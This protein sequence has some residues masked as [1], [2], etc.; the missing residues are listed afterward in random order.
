MTHAI[1]QKGNWF[2]AYKAFLFDKDESLVLK[3][4]PLVLLFGSPEIL[5]SNLLPF[6]GQAVDIGAFTI[7]AIV[8]F[9][10]YIA[11]KKHLSYQIGQ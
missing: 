3:V 11:V 8:M 2:A 4:A 7:A 9:R 1:P 10:T 5:V 6:V